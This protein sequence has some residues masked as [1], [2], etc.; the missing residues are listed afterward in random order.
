[1]LMIIQVLLA[2][3][4]VVGGAV[5]AVISVLGARKQTKGANW[6]LLKKLPLPV[7]AAWITTAVYALIY[8]VWAMQIGGTPVTRI[9]RDSTY[10]LIW[11]GKS[12]EVSRAV[13]IR[14]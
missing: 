9:A 10:S 1:M 3:I 8:N 5:W 14:S 11:A 12:T 2:L 4:V 13:Y 6:A 7:T